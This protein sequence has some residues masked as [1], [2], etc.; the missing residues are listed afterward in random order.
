[1]A[2]HTPSR[3][4]RGPLVVEFDMDDGRGGEDGWDVHDVATSFCSTDNC[5]IALRQLPAGCVVRVGS[6]VRIRSTIPIGHRFAV[7]HIPAGT[8]LSFGSASFGRASRDIEPGEHLVNARVL[9]AIRPRVDHD[10]PAEPNFE[11]M[12]EE[13][14][15]RSGDPS[16]ATR[17]GVGMQVPLVDG[18][19][20]FMGFRRRERKRCVGTRNFV[21]VVSLTADLAPLA[22]AIA[23]EAQSEVLKTHKMARLG[24]DPLHGV[25]PLTHTE[26]CGERAAS[27]ADQVVR[28]LRGLIAHPNVAGAVVCAHA[29]GRHWLTWERL[30]QAEGA[31]DAFS[32]LSFAAVDDGDVDSA[33]ALLRPSGQDDFASA[34]RKG[35]RAAVRC[36]AHG[37]RCVR[38]PEPLSFLRVAQQCGGSDA[39]SGVTANPLLGYACEWLIAR[40]G[41]ALLAETDELIGA[42]E[43]VLGR[44]ADERVAHTFLGMVHRFKAFAARHGTSAECNPS[45]GNLLRG[46]YNIRLKSLGAALK[47]APNV[48]LEGCLEYGEQMPEGTRGLFFMDSPGRRVHSRAVGARGGRR[49]VPPL[50]GA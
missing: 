18:E 44:V 48:R 27:N 9:D 42:E 43:Y 17:V 49:G 25:V 30:C 37:L 35:I 21:L 1:M 20:M 19:H 2:G 14:A 32:S 24:E 38:T 47:R 23:E 16:A 8:R 10:L 39:F 50:R 13:D 46:I 36:A 7:G 6:G 29:A 45:G 11:D 31:G 28:T 33:W 12:R 26:G 4:R 40:G 3:S 34:K 5:L 22:K 41:A 15:E